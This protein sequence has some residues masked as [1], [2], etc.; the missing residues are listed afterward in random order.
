MPLKITIPALLAAATLLLPSCDSQSVTGSAEKPEGK[1][2]C[3]ATVQIHNTDLLPLDTKVPSDTFFANQVVIL[4]APNTVDAAASSSQINS[5]TIADSIH[6][7][8]IEGTNLVKVS[9]HHDDPDTAKKIVEALLGAYTANRNQQDR[10]RTEKTLNALDR[11]LQMH[12]DI[13]Q[14]KRK[15]LTVI[16]QQ[17]GIPYFE[18]REENNIGRTEEEMY[19]RATEKLDLLEQDRNRLEIQIKRLIDTANE[20]L[21]RTAAGLELPENQVSNFYTAYLQALRNKDTALASGLGEDHP[22]VV[23]SQK[24]AELHLKDA[25]REVTTLKEILNT[26]LTLIDR[27]VERM[28]EMVQDKKD[29]TVDLSMQQHQYNSAKEEYEQ[30]RNLLREMKIQQQ[31][32]RVQIRMPR[33]PLTIHGWS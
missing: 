23:A 18:G 17:Y 1:H 25:S 22:K 2:Q 12:G 15:A 5:Q 33:T 19:R 32:A 8:P 4:S 3:T 14:E 11:E 10:D 29:N 24:Q 9:A 21:I 6:I 7:E 26:R 16:I 13:V 20:D 28:R 27:Q 31:E 30:A